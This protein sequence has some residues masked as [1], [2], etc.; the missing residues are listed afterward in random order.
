MSDLERAGFV[1]RG[2]KGDHRNY[3]HPKGIRV[4]LSGNPGDDAKPY[5]EKEVRRVIKESQS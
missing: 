1:N 4:T 5:Q 3:Q 2:G